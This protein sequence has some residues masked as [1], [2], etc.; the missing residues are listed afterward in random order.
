MVWDAAA[1]LE[2]ATSL[3]IL[4]PLTPLACRKQA[5]YPAELR[6]EVYSGGWAPAPD[7]RPFHGPSGGSYLVFDLSEFRFEFREPFH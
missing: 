4:A 3:P 1:G 6:R 7:T 5:L 2:P